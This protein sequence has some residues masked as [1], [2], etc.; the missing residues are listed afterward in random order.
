MDNPESS[1]SESESEGESPQGPENAR[2]NRV[3][4]GKAITSKT[5]FRGDLNKKLNS[6]SKE[7][8]QEIFHALRAMK[9][10][11]QDS[12]VA[13]TTYTLLFHNLGKYLSFCT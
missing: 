3:N 4:L 7:K 2:A 6:M 10:A 13:R 11:R 1:G 5:I 8:A 9:E 12:L